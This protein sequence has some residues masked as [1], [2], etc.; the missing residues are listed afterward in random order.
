MH[1]QPGGGPGVLAGRGGGPGKIVRILALTGHPVDSAGSRYRVIQFLPALRQMGFVIDHQSFFNSAEYAKLYQPSLAPRIRALAA[2]TVRR[3]LQLYRA[4]GYDLLWIHLWLHP[5]T[6]PLFDL[7]LRAI[8]VPVVYDFDDAYYEVGAATDRLR[9]RNWAP[10]LM[11]RAH[12]VVT[13]S[14]YIARVIERYNRNVKVLPTAVDT[15][16]FRPRDFDVER[17]QRPVIGWVG[18]HSTAPY[19][20]R[21]Y[22]VIQRLAR[23]HEFVFRVVGAGRALPI[24]GVNVEFV[25]WRLEH[26]ADHF[27]T[28]DIG[29][30]PLEDNELARGKHGFKLHQYMAVGVPAVASAVGLTPSVIRT[31]ENGFLATNADEWYEAL[32]RLLQD[33]ALR[34]RIG[35][36]SREEVVEKA[37]L[38]AVSGQLCRILR[39]A[40]HAQREPFEETQAM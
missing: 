19:V 2:G 37:S 21:L 25:P 40:T 5:V 33:E 39:D 1:E 32:A 14:D 31:G 13:G 9:D 20:E 24:P 29:L 23:N 38:R 6:F 28:L 17:N 11:R 27:R 12:T 18:T 35:L 36:A 10:R 30:Y 4:R 15:D 22:P 26:E 3:A 34:R 8:D 16:R 7:A